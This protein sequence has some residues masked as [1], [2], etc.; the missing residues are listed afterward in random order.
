MWRRLKVR[1]ELIDIHFHDLRAK[2][3]TDAKRKHGRDFARAL[4]GHESGEMTDDYV[5]DNPNITPLF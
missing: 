2:A 4:A 1:A 3:V 5:R